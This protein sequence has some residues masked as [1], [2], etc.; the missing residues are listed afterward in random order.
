M[1]NFIIVPGIK[2]S[3][4]RMVY[5]EFIDKSY[6]PSEDELIALYRIEP[7]KGFSIEE[8]AGRVASES[9]V[10]TWT[11][12]TTMKDHVM[13]IRA[14][15]YDF[16]GYYV[17][18]A[19]KLDLF[20]PGN[21]CQ[22]MSAIAGNVFG[23]KAVRNLRLE[24]IYWPPGIVR[25][26]NGPLFGIKGVRDLFKVY[27]R[28]LTATVPKPKVGLYPDEYAEA[29]YEIMIGG[30]DLVKDDENNT[31]M[32][33]CKFKER[34]EKVLKMRDKAEA[35]T[36]EKKGFLANITAP[37]GEMV[38]RAKFVK[39]L[40]GEYVMID[41]L[42]VG[43]SALQE[44]MKINQD[45]K[46][47]I[48]AHRAFH[49]AFTRK[50]RHGMSMKVVAEFARLLGVDQLHV[51]TV[52]GKLEA[53]KMEVFALTD[54]LRKS[55]VREKPRLKLL[56]KNWL[57]L[58]PV[59]PV[60]SGG[61]HPGLM[62]YIIKLFGVDL[63]IQAGGGVVGHPK[64]PRAGAAAL[65]QAIDAAI[66]GIELEEYAKTHWELREALKKWGYMRPK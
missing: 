61:L 53:E 45:L 40:G 29:S 18:I 33:F 21:I 19:Y 20:E 4:V 23:M 60:S 64:G 65:R 3:G 1:I 58:K 15:A 50:K 22:I 39:D 6:K 37:F 41:I 52:I 25:E 63:L 59:V 47:R 8:A 10:G 30:V 26:Y 32:K 16:N 48:H 31:S 34:V 44:F 35:E 62:P 42:T 56:A 38:K 54:I 11:E 43:W 14:L 27:D 55:K 9:S 28:P 2:L 49:A 12:V 7:A 57:S 36:G 17:K 51:G 5:L 46:L 13:A 66:K 24:D